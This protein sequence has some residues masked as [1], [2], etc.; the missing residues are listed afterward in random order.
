MSKQ[1]SDLHTSVKAVP[2]S[3]P[4]TMRAMSVQSPIAYRGHNG[5]SIWGPTLLQLS[6]DEFLEFHFSGCCRHESVSLASFQFAQL[7]YGGRRGEEFTQ[8]SKSSSSQIKSSREACLQFRRFQRKGWKMLIYLYKEQNW[9]L[10]FCGF[11]FAGI[12]A[13]LLCL[14]LFTVLYRWFV[15]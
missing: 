1:S 9:K 5:G 2:S 6:R 4:K 12:F 7:G 13:G 11:V 14:S 3:R 15:S 10:F 8:K